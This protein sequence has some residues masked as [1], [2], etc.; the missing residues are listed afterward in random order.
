MLRFGMVL[1]TLLSLVAASMADE[2]VTDEQVPAPVQPAYYTDPQAS[3]FVSSDDEAESATPAEFATFNL[4]EPVQPAA[5]LAMMPGS[6]LPAPATDFAERLFATDNVRRSLIVRSR[7][8]MIPATGT[9]FVFGSEGNFR[10]TTDGGNLLGKALSTP[11][12]NTQQRTP[13]ITDP[14]VRGSQSGR[15]VAS[16][17]Y[18]APA[19]QDLDTM[20]S[21]ID[22]RLLQDVIVI[23]GPYSAH[24]GPGYNFID[25]QLLQTPRYFC[26]PETHSS[27][28]AEFKSNGQ[29]WY[30]RETLWGGGEG[31]GWRASYGHRTGNDYVD[32]HGMAYPSSYN[33]GDLNLAYGCDFSPDSHLELN[34]LRLDQS[35]VEFPY[36]VFDINYLAT[37]GYEL[38]YVLENQTQ[39][40][41]LT[42][43]AWY[44]RTRFTGDTSRP[45]K[46]HQIPEIREDNGL[47][48]DQFLTTDV[49]GMSTGYRAAMSW[50]LPGEPILTL[51]T[52]LIRIGQQLNDIVPAH[53]EDVGFPLPIP[54]QNFP[55][56]R[57]N[58]L[59]VGLFAEHSR[60][61]SD[62]LRV[63]L[64]ARVDLVTTNSRNN[65]PGM[66]VLTGFPPV[67]VET[68]LS[69]LKQAELEQHFVPWNVYV[70]GEYQFTDCHFLNGGVGH[71]SR[72]PTLTELYAYGP[73]IGSLQP[74]LTFVQGDPTLD[75]EEC[76]QIDIGA[77]A[78]LGDR[79]WSISGFYAWI[80][81]YITYDDVGRRY[82]PPFP[83]FDPGHD[84]QEVAY[85]NTALATLIGFEYL[86]EQDVRDD[87]TAF[88]VM[89]YVA[90][91]DHT[92][93]K[94]SRI[95][96]M[97][98]EE[99]FLP[100]APRSLFPGNSEPLPGI[101][102]L[103][104]RL[105]LRWHDPQP[106]PYWALELEARLVAEQTRVATSL[107]EQQTPGFEVF[108]IRG[109]WRPNDCLTLIG[110]IE[111][112]TN[113]FYREHLDYRPGL[114]TF[115]P[116]INFYTAV[117][118]AY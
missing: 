111:N 96:A 58:S 57:S 104:A 72:P 86:G 62:V 59:D 27:T 12:V 87:L 39:F 46:N 11:S 102:P 115:R 16:G 103:Q 52:D 73:F 5:P 116:G 38:K 49:D 28:S 50:G 44:N 97:L 114:Q 33:S 75:A 6:G 56:P 88:L 95:G 68:S 110:G 107:F 89:N 13:I 66:G 41:L 9:E 51:G 22:S 112:F 74:G 70:T 76:T 36:L 32:G 91:T 7:R 29:Q 109:F 24:Y 90:G 21:K 98:R 69:D 61:V 78:D 40:D 19:R 54:E 83:P 53:T 42:V 84:F 65:V 23:K 71:A 47:G 92:R 82:Q 81:D 106:N 60:P 99:A 25:F 117:E 101:P 31:Y 20:L 79:R 4:Q 34:Y 18:W 100:P 55:I 85:T 3:V 45:G 1:L 105:G 30:G 94:P 67:L 35:N 108:N 113:R 63:N 10:V 26:G 37:D 2:L 118:L 15:T 80:H 17:S 14:R 48:P 64:G 43:D 77:R 93:A 8:E